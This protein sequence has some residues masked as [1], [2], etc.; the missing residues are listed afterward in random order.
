MW[1]TFVVVLWIHLFSYNSNTENCL[2]TVYLRPIISLCV[3]SWLCL[4]HCI[5]DPRVEDV[6]LSISKYF[7][8]HYIDIYSR[9]NERPRF[10][11]RCSPAET[12]HQHPILVWHLFSFLFVG[13]RLQT[14]NLT[15]AFCL[16]QSLIGPKGSLGRTYSGRG[17]IGLV[18]FV[19]ERKRHIEIVSDSQAS[20]NNAIL[21][22]TQETGDKYTVIYLRTFCD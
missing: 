6:S 10:L 8:F 3:C 12:P 5:Y 9:A 14:A 21:R 17:W 15:T 7:N 2:P 1:L 4:P 16:C 19:A 20:P 18:M 13:C 11:E 22:S